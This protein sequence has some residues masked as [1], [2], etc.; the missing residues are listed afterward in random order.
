MNPAHLII[1]GDSA[2][3]GLSLAL[4]QVIRDSGLPAPAGGVLISP[5]CDLTHSFPSV[6]TNTETDIIP[7][8][9]LSFQKP[10]VLWPPPSDAISRQVHSSLRTRLR[11]AFKTAGSEGVTAAMLARCRKYSSSGRPV[12]VGRTASLGRSELECSQAISLVSS[13]GELLST[14]R[15]LHFY[16]PNNLLPHPLVSPVLSYLGG[17][18]PLFIVAGDGEVLR[19]EIVYLSH[20]AACP[21]KYPVTDNARSLYPALRGIEDKHLEPTKIHLQ[22]YD[23]TPHVFPVLFSFSTPAKFCF[24]AIAAFC[25][26]ATGMPPV[27]CSLVPDSVTK[28]S[29]RPSIRSVLSS[30]TIQL[31]F[32]N[33][34]A[35]TFFQSSSQPL[36]NLV[37]REKLKRSTSGDLRP[38]TTDGIRKIQ[39]ANSVH[40][41]TFLPPS[42]TA[43]NVLE[44]TGHRVPDTPHSSENGC[45]SFASNNQ[46]E[47]KAGR[48][49]AY[50]PSGKY[51]DGSMI[52][53][54]VSVQG[55]IRPLESC[56]ALGA[57]GVP[58][59]AIG[60]LSELT[61]RRYLNAQTTFDK[62]FS[63][64][65]AKIEE[66]RRRNL[67]ISRED[68][69]RS[70]QLLQQSLL[71]DDHSHSNKEFHGG[72]SAVSGNWAWILDEG[73]SPPPSSIVSR[74]DTAEARRLARVADQP[75]TKKEPAFSGN[76]LWAAIVEHLA[77]K[78]QFGFDVPKNSSTDSG[79]RPSMF[80]RLF[81]SDPGIS[82]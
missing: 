54:R 34:S 7:A 16:A 8:W 53:E 81:R 76:R 65:T 50:G 22:V 64:T 2:G 40:S 41:S 79:K 51:W 38:P 74:R 3:G 24:R 82:L 77:A 47:L 45:G 37:R 61:L 32:Q 33:S 10:S 21:D 36:C 55:L 63:Y 69:T 66:E 35:A 1:A 31:P 18:P 68:T 28:R 11:E 62:K 5:W 29:R 19:D 14:D 56:S 80:S 12:D 78:P 72:L 52:R 43:A 6:H 49:Y 15:Q 42:H 58:P 20:K 70:I 57:F 26:F 67:E 73:E 27:A 59:D 39:R 71:R 44:E 4:L 60:Q 17:L 46:E 30:K 75:G 48:L 25:K 13:S 9:G 23:D